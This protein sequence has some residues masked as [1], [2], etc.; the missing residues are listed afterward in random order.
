MKSF[1]F[2]CT[3]LFLPAVVFA[4]Q[5]VIAEPTD[6]R[7]V[8]SIAE[9]SESQEFFG[10]LDDFPHTFEFEVTETMPF[11][12]TVFVADDVLQNNDVSIIIVKAERRGVSEVGRTRAKEVSWEVV[13][14]RV[15][16][17]RFRSGGVLEGTLE[18]SWYK[19]EVSAPNNDAVYRL[20][21]GTGKVRHGY[22]GSVRALFEVKAFLGHSRFGALLS[23]L[24]YI[25]LLI[26][27]AV[28]GFIYYRKRKRT[29]S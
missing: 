1:L 3:F 19:L 6:A 25:P 27:I 8:L 29:L 21:W 5:S 28:A 9:V 23:P 10:R 2:L 22:F 15:F 4:Y 17:E 18:P 7:T 13:N 20:V 26:V 16:V 24:L 12:A 11:K 14:D